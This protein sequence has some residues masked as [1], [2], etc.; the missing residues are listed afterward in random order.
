MLRVTPKMAGS[1]AVA[2][3]PSTRF[4]SFEG[5]ARS[6]KTATAI[7]AFYYRVYNSPD[8]FHLIA[9]RDLS[10][11]DLNLLNASDIGLLVTHSDCTLKKPSIGSHYI[12]LTGRDGKQKIIRLASYSNRSSWKK[13][14]GSSLGVILIDEIN[15][16]EEDFV[17]ETFARQ[18]NSDCPFTICTLNGDDPSHY[19]YQDY[20]NYCQIRGVPP[21]STFAEMT[22]FQEKAGT[23]SGYVYEFYGMTDNP[24]MTKGKLEAAK[25]LY[26]NGSFY[27]HTKIL[28]ERGV[29]GDLIFDD[30]LDPTKQF[31]RVATSRSEN[32]NELSLED[33]DSFTI[34]ADI[35]ASKAS[36]VFVLVGWTRRARKAVILDSVH[37]QQIGYDGKTTKL[38]QFIESLQSKYHID[39][40]RIEGIFVDSA[41]SNYIMDLAPKIRNL[42]RIPV[43]GSYKATILDRI[44][45]MIIGISSGKILFKE[46]TGVEIYRAFRKALWTPGKKGKERL[47]NNELHN[48]QMDATEYALTRHMK[49]LMSAEHIEG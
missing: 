39:L 25:S 8:Q 6:A 41:E 26:P 46:D 34:G 7:Q 30:Y 42:Y 32:R 16:A 47:D 48:D 19:V 37:F 40:R 31:V 2:I 28:G 5:P 12:T 15:I 27:F 43:V 11:I 44:N 10:V 17:N 23:K 20:I 33:F 49:A 3:S 4:Y 22:R 38:R 14:L 24:T 18:L 13:V 21:A 45:M 9:A 35:G 36:N 29:Q 1:L